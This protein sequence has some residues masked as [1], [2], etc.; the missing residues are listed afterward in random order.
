MKIEEVDR[1][2][3]QDLK[4]E[5]KVYSR[6]STFIN[7]SQIGRCLGWGSD[8]TRELM[9]DCEHLPGR[10]HLYYIGD[11]ADRIMAQREM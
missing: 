7:L 3:K 8:R 11:V 1:M 2:N 10:A 4:R 9:A 5:L 6:G